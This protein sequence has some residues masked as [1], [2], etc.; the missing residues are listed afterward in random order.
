MN[1]TIRLKVA[2][3]TVA[4]VIAFGTVGYRVIEGWPWFESLYLTTLLLAS[5]GF[6]NFQPGSEAG[7]GFTILLALCGVAV[8]A[9]AIASMTQLIIGGQI[10]AILGR[11]KMRREVGKLWSHYIICGYGRMGRMVAKEL[12]A[13]PLPVVIVEKDPA[14]VAQIDRDEINVVEGDATLEE[15]L[16]MAGIERAKGLITVVSSD[17][18]NLYIVL[19]ARGL[20]KNLVIVARA[21]EEKSEQ[22]L[23]Q[24]GANK[25]IS[26]YMIGGM[27]IAQAVLRPNVVDFIELATQSEHMELQM[28]EIPI[29]KNSKLA[30]MTL[31]DS[32]IRIELG[33]IVVAIKKKSGHMEYN[34][35]AMY[36]IGSEDTLIVLG[37]P[38]RIKVL[39]RL[40]GI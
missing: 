1:Y 9:F 15:T 19:S 3:L 2:L 4:A 24:A 35:P 6:A 23:I 27:R 40:A 11:R 22:K 30:G 7:R 26:P 28:E 32:G 5:F 10:E 14:L 37:Q 8:I 38:E 13:K 17:A 21:G 16:V 36:T 33:I 18:E 31:K 29:Q 25:V 20:N 39:E 34:P 12:M